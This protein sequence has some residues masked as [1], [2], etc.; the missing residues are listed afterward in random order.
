ML[1]KFLQRF[2]SMQRSAARRLITYMYVCDTRQ[3]YTINLQIL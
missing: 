1:N 3:I 2:T